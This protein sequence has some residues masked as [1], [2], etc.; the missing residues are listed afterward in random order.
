MKYTTKVKSALALAMSLMVGASFA[1]TNATV[2]VEK[3]SADFESPAYTLGDKISTATYRDEVAGTGWFVGSVEDDESAISN[4]LDAAGGQML[5]LNTDSNTLT[6]KFAGA[7]DVNTAIA[8]GAKTGAEYV[9][10]VANFGGAYFETEVK[11]V[12]SDD[13]K[14]DIAGGTDAT[15]FA[16]YAY[17]D[18]DDASTP[19]KLV[20]FHAIFDPVNTGIAYCTNEVFD[21]DIDVTKYTKV[22]VEMKKLEDPEDF[23]HRKYNAFSVTIDGVTIANP[24]TALD[25]AFDGTAPGQWFMTVEDSETAAYTEVSSL[26]FKGTGEID[27]VKVGQI[28]NET[29]EAKLNGV[30][31]ADFA[32]AAAALTSADAF[33]AY[34][35]GSITL[36]DGETY[37]IDTNGFAVAVQAGPGYKAVY[38]NGAWKSVQDHVEA[39]VISVADGT[40][41]SY[42]TLAEALAA[43]AAGDTV[44][45]LDDVVVD[46]TVTIS[47]NLVF[48]LGGYSLTNNA[49]A[50]VFKALAGNVVVTNGTLYG[51]VNCY[52]ASTLTIATN[53]TVEGYV[54]VWGDGTYGESGCLT[55]TLNVYGTVNAEGEGAVAVFNG[56]GDTS[57]PNINVY[58][59]A[60][61]NADWGVILNEAVFTMSGGTINANNRGVEATKGSSVTIS[62]GT[63]DAVVSGIG[64]W[65]ASTLT[66]TGGDITAGDFGVFNNGLEATG[67]TM[68]I[69]GGTIT[70]DSACGIYQAGLG[71]LTLS[72]TA[73]VTGPDAVEVRA[74]SVQVL[75]HARLVATA[76]YSDPV[77]NGGGSS[78]TGGVALLISQHTTAQ[79]VSATVDGGTLTGAVAFAEVTLEASNDSEK[80]SGAINGGV[81]Y[82]SVVSDDLEGLIPANSTA[83]FSD[84]QPEGLPEGYEVVEDLPDNPGLYKVQAQTFTV[85]FVAENETFATS[86]NIAYNTA[87]G[88]P[89]PAPTK[90]DDE[91][92]TYAFNAWK[93]GDAVYD[94][95]AGVTSNFTLVADFTATAKPQTYTVSWAGSD[96]VVVS[97]ATEQL[98]GTS[99]TFEADTVLTFYP[100]EGTITN[101]N[102]VAQDPGLANYPYT[103]TT[104][105]N[106]AVV[107][108]AGEASAPVSDDYAAGDSITGEVE[109]MSAE[110]AAWLNAKKGNA[111]KAEFE[112]AFD[113]DGY[114]LDQEYLLNT[115]PTVAT[116]VEFKINS[117]AVGGTVDLQVVLTRTEGG[118]AVESA[119]NGTLKIKGAATVDGT[120]AVDQ[121]LTDK[122]SGGAA[123]TKSFS[124][125]NK[126]F[127]AV[128]E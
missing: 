66:M 128:I 31:Y 88:A 34:A 127:K 107:V 102:G 46:S 123:A 53:T 83:L 54:V 24:E 97:N 81:L 4:R 35:A 71:A 45:L 60:E 111:T 47:Q 69:S 49:G 122:F 91:T 30:K 100:T 27:N 55:P 94:F 51:R 59:G 42:P 117:I 70:S 58:D 93:L 41:T 115:D 110:M 26:N 44:Q 63:I 39:T 104:A 2:T 75:D 62:G 43:A 8:G 17:D 15:K 84:S 37:N 6:N 112:A 38:E 120:Y 25:S 74:G 33:V 90:A 99:G 105:D 118:S 40:S 20:V 85:I 89:D 12:A 18:D 52:D 116:T 56:N 29:Y 79:N 121:T 106:Q 76:S 64:L 101:V 119:I 3:Y 82:G 87:V 80:I 5:W 36:A 126:F 61:I 7:T 11:F 50:P 114:T 98:D 78:G 23:N 21:V 125:E 19:A 22:C 65:E 92:Y 96:K 109:G 32:T 77:S 57:K 113:D 72:G 86:N 103:V 124:T 14:V 10:N 108:L 48:D 1:A 73:V 16:I 68:T 28:V 13:A 67:T 9:G 95:T